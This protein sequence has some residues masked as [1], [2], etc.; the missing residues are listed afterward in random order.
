MFGQDRISTPARGEATVVIMPLVEAPEV[1]RIA[2]IVRQ[3]IVPLIA[4]VI[5][6]VAME[7]ATTSVPGLITPR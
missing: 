7:A 4:G 5:T 1:L 6:N 3:L 2:I